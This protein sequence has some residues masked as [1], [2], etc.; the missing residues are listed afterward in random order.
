MVQKDA[1]FAIVFRFK[2]KDGSIACRAEKLPNDSTTVLEM[3]RAEIQCLN[4]PCDQVKSI[5]SNILS[6]CRIG[7]EIVLDKKSLNSAFIE[8]KIEDLMNEVIEND[9][10]VVELL[11]KSET[12]ELPKYK[13]YVSSIY[14]KF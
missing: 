4:E 1:Y 12:L 11:H 13:L 3:I 8:E 9:L 2:L 10:I 14:F 5:C 6:I 7:S